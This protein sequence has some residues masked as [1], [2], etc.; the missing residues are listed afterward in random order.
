MPPKLLDRLSPR[1]LVLALLGLATAVKTLWATT[2]VGT[3]DAV[4]FFHFGRSIQS[5]GLAR[6]YVIDKVF[7]HTPFTGWTMRMLYLISQGD[8]LH[9]AE[10]LRMLC[11]LADIA[12]VL[13]LLHVRK[14]T[15]KPPW[16]AL[17]LFA[18]S[19]VSIMVSGFH[20]NIDPIMVMFLF[21][22]AVAV[23]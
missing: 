12:M 13:G 23:L 15:G 14:L 20:G 22:A 5:H 9:F 19:P 11:I 21:L 4:L 18:A 7:N 3:T 16:W 10:G 17:C 2:S 6:M 1:T 8:Y